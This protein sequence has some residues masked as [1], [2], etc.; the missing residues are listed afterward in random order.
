MQNSPKDINY[1]EKEHNFYLEEQILK[2]KLLFHI[3]NL[4][5]ELESC[6][7]ERMDLEI[8]LETTTEHADLVEAQLHKEVIERQKAEL[9]LYQANQELEKLSILDSLTQVANR[10]KFDDY[11]LQQ[12]QIAKQESVPIS[13]IMCDIDYFKLYNDTYGHPIGDYCLQQVALAIDCIL[14]SSIDLIAR[15]GGEEFAII[16]PNTDE[17]RAIQMAEKIRLSIKNLKIIHNKSSVDNYLTI[18]LGVFTI[19]PTSKISPDLLILLADKALYQAKAQ[20]RDRV[21]CGSIS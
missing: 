8:M 5:E 18:S 12:W 4:R 15:Y 1:W 11:L 13:L 3:E 9:A 2:E 21:K 16:L 20:G 17:D 6:K 19:I 7:Q 10:R 14:E